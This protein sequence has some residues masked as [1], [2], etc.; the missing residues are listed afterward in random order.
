MRTHA[1]LVGWS[2]ELA[3]S[4][5]ADLGDRG[6][7]VEAVATKAR[8]ISEIVGGENA[9]CL[10]AAAYLHDIGVS[11]SLRRTGFHPIDGARYLRAQGE[12]RLAGLV[13]NHSGARVEA[14]LR[15]VA[16]ELAEFPDEASPTRD[17]LWYCDLTTGPTGHPTSVVARLADVETRYGPDHVVARAMQQALPDLQA[18]VTRTEGRLRVA[19]LAG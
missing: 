5:L 15:G 11:P 14:A 7:H 19:G 18:A 10:V 4:L 16:S 13:A 12:D 3:E 8:R 6:R 1:D 9:S 17:A 2:A